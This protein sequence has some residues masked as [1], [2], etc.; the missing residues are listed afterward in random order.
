MVFSEAEYEAI[1]KAINEGITKVQELF[2]A[3]IDK[4]NNLISFVKDLAKWLF[5]RIVDAIEL[6][7]KAINAV[8][9]FIV[10]CLKGALAPILFFK[11]GA[12]WHN[13]VKGPMK[14]YAAS[15]APDKLLS[16]DQ[17]EGAAGN[18]YRE[19]TADQKTAGDACATI[20][21]QMGTNL[22][23]CAGGGLAFYVTLG[24]CVAKIIT[25][26]TAA[27]A[28]STTVVAAP[29]AA[30][31]AGAVSAATIAEITAACAGLAAFLGTQATTISNVS[32]AFSEFP[33]SQWPSG[34][35]KK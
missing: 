2:N 16:S 25:A 24:I 26:I 35:S 7:R 4:I 30:A 21:S 28:A 34:T 18:R 11:R 5:D 14:R 10:E 15:V 6:L 1:I 22:I 32:S 17:W 3:F 12:D 23:V 9:Q 20:G 27:A 13:N 19:A 29:A 31:G 8:I 33:Y